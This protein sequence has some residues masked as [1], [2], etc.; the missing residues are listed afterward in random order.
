[1]AAHVGEHASED[2][3]R[4][5]RMQRIDLRV[6]GAIEIV[7]VVALNG[8]MQ[9]RKAQRQHQR[10]DDERLFYQACLTSGLERRARASTPAFR[11]GRAA[12]RRAAPDGR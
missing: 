7:K 2:V 6:L 10:G 12:G 9:K 5:L 1:M 11:A 8:L 4:V 3:A